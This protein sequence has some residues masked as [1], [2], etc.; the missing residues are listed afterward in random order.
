MMIGIDEGL[1]KVIWVANKF[2]PIKLLQ[3]CLQNE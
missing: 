3:I 2:Q 1:I